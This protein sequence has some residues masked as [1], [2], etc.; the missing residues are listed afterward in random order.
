MIKLMLGH[1]CGGDKIK[2][3]IKLKIILQSLTI[4]NSIK[5]KNKT[6]L[7]RLPKIIK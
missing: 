7:L 3:Q 6:I 4:N 2:T 5:N 1:F